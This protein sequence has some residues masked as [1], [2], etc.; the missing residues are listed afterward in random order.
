MGVPI[1]IKCELE[2]V[3]GKI[4]DN[5]TCMNSVRMRLPT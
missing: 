1:M 4:D 5:R 3:Q 2:E